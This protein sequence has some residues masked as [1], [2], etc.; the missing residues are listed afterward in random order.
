MHYLRLYFFSR[1]ELRVIGEVWTSLLRARA[2]RWISNRYFLGRIRRPKREYVLFW[3]NF[4]TCR[5][6][7][8]L[9]TWDLCD[10]LSTRREV[11]TRGI[12]NQGL[13]VFEPARNH[14]AFLNPR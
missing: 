3:N 13:A 14:A 10:F 9:A 7:L 12:L 11:L 6:L 5:I 2:D 4:F 8:H 1:D